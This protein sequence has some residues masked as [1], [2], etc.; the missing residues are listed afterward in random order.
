MPHL[1]VL[2]QIKFENRQAVQTEDSVLAY[3]TVILSCNY[4]QNTQ[5]QTKTSFPCWKNQPI[6]KKKKKK[7]KTS[8]RP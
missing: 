3:Q 6:K 8:M 2:S 4:W 1:E 5:Y 7:K